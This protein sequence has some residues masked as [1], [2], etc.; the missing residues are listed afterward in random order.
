ML[1][2]CERDSYDKLLH[3]LFLGDS[4]SIIESTNS[5]PAATRSTRGYATLPLKKSPKKQ[6]MEEKHEK[7][8]ASTGKNKSTCNVPVI[9]EESQVEKSNS[10]HSDCADSDHS[11][12][13]ASK[14]SNSTNNKTQNLDQDITSDNAKMAHVS[15][16][17]ALNSKNTYAGNKKCWTVTSV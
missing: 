15:P 6:E 9:K 11:N 3:T 12:L 14:I 5:T 8:E 7:P 10:S 4:D 13:S 16:L 2:N 17:N 1:T